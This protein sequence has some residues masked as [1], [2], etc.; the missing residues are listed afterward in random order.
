MSGAFTTLFY[1]VCGTNAGEN[2]NRLNRREW[3]NQIN[4]RQSKFTH[5]PIQIYPANDSYTR[6]SNLFWPAN[7]ANERERRRIVDK[8]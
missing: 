3:Q 6:V 7:E 8:I 1:F 2:E 4:L 5:R